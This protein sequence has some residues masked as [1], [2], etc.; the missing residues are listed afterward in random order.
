MLYNGTILGSRFSA[1]WGW[2]TVISASV[3][4][5]LLPSRW[6]TIRATSSGLSSKCSMRSWQLSAPAWKDKRASLY[7]GLWKPHSTTVRLWISPETIEKPATRTQSIRSTEIEM[8][9]FKY[10]PLLYFSAVFL[11]LNEKKHF[12]LPNM[13]FSHVLFLLWMNWCSLCRSFRDF[14]C[15]WLH[16]FTLMDYKYWLRCQYRRL[17]A[18]VHCKLRKF[19]QID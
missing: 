15:Y 18:H 2:K 11:Y 16:I 4:T 8:I 14:T 3:L 7:R 1:S 13:Y 12:L 5:A 9:H 6:P 17:N 19:V 10:T